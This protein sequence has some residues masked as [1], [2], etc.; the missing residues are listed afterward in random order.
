MAI[1]LA[2]HDRVF[3][4]GAVVVRQG[5]PATALYILKSGTVM[6]VK[7]MDDGSE[8]TLD[9]LGFGALFGEMA[10]LDRA[11]RSASVI[12]VQL[13]TCVEIPGEL[14]HEQVRSGGPLVP[15]ILRVMALRLRIASDQLAQLRMA[16]SPGVA[17]A[18]AKPDPDS[19]RHLARAVRDLET[20]V[21]S[22]S[23]LALPT[24]KSG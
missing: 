11:P 15:I 10:L 7:H 13:S 4:P 16:Q 19:A 2:R 23:D 12:A 17:P 21:L 5:D 1:N 6:V 8:V 18:V 9:V 3:Q 22:W 20:Q 14:V 24:T